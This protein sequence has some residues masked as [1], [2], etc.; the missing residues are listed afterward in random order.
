MEVWIE[1]YLMG[2]IGDLQ[3]SPPTWRCGLK[4]S[5]NIKLSHPLWS[6]PTWRCGLKQTLYSVNTLVLEV[7]SHVEVWIE[8][9]SYST[10]IK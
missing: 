2:K 6:P 1:T 7:T 5:S 8:T 4:L 10:H 9:H 3:K